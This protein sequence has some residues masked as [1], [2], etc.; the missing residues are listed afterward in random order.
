MFDRNESEMWKIN[1]NFLYTQISQ[2]KN[3]ILSHNH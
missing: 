3:F 1:K 2:E